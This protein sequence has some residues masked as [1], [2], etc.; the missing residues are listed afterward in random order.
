MFSGQKMIS[1]LIEK[2]W[3]DES[4]RGSQEVSK[5]PRM[6]SQKSDIQGALKFDFLF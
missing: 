1:R 2:A 4:A 3:A 6:E 5:S